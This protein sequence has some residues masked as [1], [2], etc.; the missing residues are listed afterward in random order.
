MFGYLVRCWAKNNSELFF[1]NDKDINWKFYPLHGKY[2]G[3]HLLLKLHFYSLY[4][5]QMKSV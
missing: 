5:N 3:V 2:V 1:K 4:N